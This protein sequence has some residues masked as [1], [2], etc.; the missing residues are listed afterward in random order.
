MDFEAN[1]FLALQRSAIY[2]SMSNVEP[3]ISL[4]WSEEPKGRRTL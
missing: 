3:D 4:L 1:H 2:W